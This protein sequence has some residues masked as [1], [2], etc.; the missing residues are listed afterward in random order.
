M[1][2][3]IKRFVLLVVAPI[4]VFILSY[5]VIQRQI[6]NSYKLKHEY[7]V[8]NGDSIELLVLGS[9]HGFYGFNPVYFRLPAF[10]AANVSQ[11]LNYDWKILS[12]YKKFMPNLKVIVLPLLTS[13]FWGD[14]HNGSESY[15]CAKYKIYMPELNLNE[16]ITNSF[17]L[18]NPSW[19]SLLHF[20]FSED[21][22][23][24]TSQGFGLSY[25]YNNRVANLDETGKTAAKRHNVSN[26][27][28]GYDE[29]SK[30][31]DYLCKFC[32]DNNINP[33]AEL[34]I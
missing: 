29:K 16:T 34:I 3:F 7:L 5:E 12:S 11:P 26:F 20:I 14:L 19:S 4:F 13:A 30:A 15:R 22:L 27:V 10:N 32:T 6:P 1:G 8:N 24:T 28:L 31:F 23:K 9:S 25:S 17:E 33:L 18:F 21:M 2:T